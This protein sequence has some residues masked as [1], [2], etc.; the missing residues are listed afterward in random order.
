[1]LL[2]VC[3]C[4]SVCVRVCVLVVFVC[5]VHVCTRVCVILLYMRQTLHFMTVQ[6]QESR[7]GGEG[8]L[9]NENPP[10]TPCKRTC[11]CPPWVPGAGS[12]GI[13][14][15]SLSFP[16]Q[17]VLCHSPRLAQ[18]GHDPYPHASSRLAFS[19][20]FR[21]SGIHGTKKLHLIFRY[22]HHYQLHH[23]SPHLC[24][25]CHVSSELCTVGV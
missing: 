9:V 17:F 5:F 10:P 3:V 4:V 24:P 15:F 1:M 8:V 22:H 16:S 14:S 13:H 2:F 21:R 7:R 6:L 25:T 23:F 12:W 18:R 11:L 20:P 19:M